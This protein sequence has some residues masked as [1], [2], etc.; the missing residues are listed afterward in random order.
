M[1]RLSRRVALIVA[2][3]ASTLGAT[4]LVATGCGQGTTAPGDGG[5]DA[6]ADVSSDSSV[7]PD[8]IATGDAADG[9]PGD[10]P[11]DVVADAAPDVVADAAPDVIA[12][13]AVDAPTLAAFPSAVVSAF[14]QRESECCFLNASTFNATL[15]HQILGNPATG[16]WV[17]IARYEQFLDG[18]TVAYDPVQAAL[19]IA[20][21]RNVGCGFLTAQSGVTIEHDCYSA[22]AGTVALDGSCQSSVECQGLAYC[23][24]TDGGPGSGSCVPLQPEGGPCT[25]TATSEEC[26]H[27]GHGVPGEYC[28]NGTCSPALPLDAGC[29][30]SNA[31]CQS[32]ICYGGTC[33]GGQVLSDPGVANGFCDFF[34][35]KDA[36]GD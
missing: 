4:A 26:S 32:L 20:E 24:G 7:A 28:S 5:L 15:C 12:D 17:D 9:G 29:S 35:I 1:G 13:A 25:N 30:A 16:G 11:P 18:G 8:S 21:S 19:C 34:T 14:C 36:G 3:G 10:A 31:A 33:A 27:L 23:R 2:F 6:T 22:L